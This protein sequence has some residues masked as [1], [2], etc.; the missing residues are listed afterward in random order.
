MTEGFNQGSDTTGFR[1]LWQNSNGVG[2]ANNGNLVSDSLSKEEFEKIFKDYNETEG[3]EALDLDDFDITDNGQINK[4]DIFQKVLEKRMNKVDSHVQ[5]WEHPAKLQEV[6]LASDPKKQ[7]GIVSLKN[8]LSIDLN[9]DQEK[10]PDK[11]K[12]ELGFSDLL[13]S[14]TNEKE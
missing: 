5:P 14:L 3:F 13:D 8:L 1:G 9:F 6:R 2:K 10:W 11:N 4:G 7:Q 12:K